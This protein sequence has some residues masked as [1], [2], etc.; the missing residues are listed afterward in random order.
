MISLVFL[1]SDISLKKTR[2]LFSSVILPF[3][4]SPHNVSIHERT[5]SQTL[6]LDG[7]D[8]VY[9]FCWKFSTSLSSQRPEFF[10]QIYEFTDILELHLSLQNFSVPDAV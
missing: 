1:L 10:E 5:F 6:A 3:C 2:Q 8:I 7:F 9:I 4:L